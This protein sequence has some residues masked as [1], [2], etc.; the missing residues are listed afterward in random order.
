MKKYIHGHI[1]IP[2]YSPVCAQAIRSLLAKM[3]GR[4]YFCTGVGFSYL[5]SMILFLMMSPRSISENYHN[6]HDSLDI[7]NNTFVSKDVQ[8]NKVSLKIGHF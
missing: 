1:L 7:I 8:I 4:A 2:Q 3:I 5:L 6:K